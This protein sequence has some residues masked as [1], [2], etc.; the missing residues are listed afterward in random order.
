M[1]KII[2]TD[3][4]RFSNEK[5]VCIAGIDI[6]NGE[7]I[8]PLPYLTIADC[9]KS[10]ILPGAVLSGRFKSSPGMQI[11]HTEDMIHENLMFHGPCSDD[12]FRSVLSNSCTKSIEKGFDV[13]LSRF[14][15]HISPESNVTKS[16]ITISVH[17]SRIKVVR[18][19]L[20]K[21]K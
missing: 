21:Q 3:L 2:I 14:Q 17:P 16:I 10:N 18:M 5:F 9:K 7:C 19:H 1:R 12:D 6:E 4:T 15:K 8:R 13:S 11:P 20:I